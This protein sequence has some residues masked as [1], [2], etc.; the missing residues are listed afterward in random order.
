[1]ITNPLF[2]TKLI[3]VYENEIKTEKATRIKELEMERTRATQ[4]L[5]DRTVAL[6][7]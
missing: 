7:S 6:H 2:Y 1:M 5:L 4:C 3:D